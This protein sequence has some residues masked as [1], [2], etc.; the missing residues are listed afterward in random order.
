M[1]LTKRLQAVLDIV[2]KENHIIDV[3]TDH[4]YLAAAL[5][6]SG[7]AQYVVASDI[8]KEPLESAERFIRKEGLEESSSCRLGDGLTVLEKDEQ[9][10]V[11]IIC[12]M[13]GLEMIKIISEAPGFTP[14]YV[15]SPQRNQRELRKYLV[16]NGYVIVYENLIEDM[17]K[18]YE[19]LVAVHEEGWDF[20]KAVKKKEQYDEV[21]YGEILLN[22]SLF[23]EC[24]LKLSFLAEDDVWWDVGP[25]LVNA[26]K[27]HKTHE[28][29]ENKEQAYPSVQKKLFEKHVNRLKKKRRKEW[30]GQE[31]RESPDQGRISV[32]K[33]EYKKLEEIIVL[34]KETGYD[35]NR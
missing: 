14:L 2:P 23:N 1:K 24:L 29:C 33:G 8:H 19:I 12:G 31:K 26:C 28:E 6:A 10:D 18:I 9:M 22:T 20:S 4:G 35:N 17:N 11:A 7:R 13:G 21:P 3:G 34:C 25:M 15:L 16:K 30:E 27:I 32:L 5:L